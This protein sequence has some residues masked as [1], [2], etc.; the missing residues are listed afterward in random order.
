MAFY[1]NDGKPVRFFCGI[2]GQDGLKEDVLYGVNESGFY[3]VSDG[4]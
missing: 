1:D 3:A 2:I 4:E